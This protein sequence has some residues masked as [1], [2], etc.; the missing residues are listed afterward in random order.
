MNEWYARC[1]PLINLLFDGFLILT[2]VLILLRICWKARAPLWNRLLIASNTLLLIAA[3]LNIPAI[4]IQLAGMF[5]PG[6]YHSQVMGPYG[7]SYWIIL[8]ARTLLPQILWI[9]KY[10]RRYRIALLLALCIAA[11]PFMEL[12]IVLT[13]DN[14][15]DY[16][17]SSWTYNMPQWGLFL[18]S[19][20]GYILLTYLVSRINRGR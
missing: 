14:H 18:A 13:M 3:M 11:G 9:K 8:L 10:R 15:R 20:A 2:P 16:R 4:L 7:Y 1:S 17:H 19:F 5:P 6:A 12:V